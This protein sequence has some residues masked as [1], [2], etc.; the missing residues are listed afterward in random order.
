MRLPLHLIFDSVP[1]QITT[2]RTFWV[3]NECLYM[4]RDKVSRRFHEEMIFLKSENFSEISW[5]F[6][7]PSLAANEMIV[8]I[9]KLFDRLNR[10]VS[11]IKSIFYTTSSWSL[12][13]FL[14]NW[15][16][17]VCY[18]VWI[19]EHP[20]LRETKSSNID[21][22]V[23]TCK[24]E[25]KSGKP[26]ALLTHFPL[27]SFSIS[28]LT[29]T[30]LRQFGQIYPRRKTLVK[31]IIFQTPSSPLM[32]DPA[33]NLR[34]HGSTPLESESEFLAFKSRYSLKRV[35]REVEFLFKDY[36]PVDALLRT[37]R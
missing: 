6:W 2:S 4:P 3:V 18:A 28:S 26:T 25:K 10:D 24:S 14:E 36:F 17:C 27:D 1:E 32:T 33:T 12:N 29:S 13:D 11:R 30:S 31:D 5:N 37:V 15:N 8:E 23:M 7:N 19:Y 21:S 35:H 16:E 20:T 9:I 22:T 34:F